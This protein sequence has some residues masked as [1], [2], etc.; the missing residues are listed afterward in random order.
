MADCECLA[1]CPFFNDRMTGMP[2][3]AEI[4]KKQYCRGDFANCA[5]F[6]IREKLGK[7]KVPS[8]LF[9]NQMDRARQLIRA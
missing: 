9:P 5:R 6:T 4:M 2:A 8:D 3:M 7:D 1:A